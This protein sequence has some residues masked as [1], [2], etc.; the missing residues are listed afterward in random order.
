MSS[1][2]KPRIGGISQQREQY[3]TIGGGARRPPEHQDIQTSE[4][5]NVQAPEPLNI[6][7]SERL[8][9]QTS[10]RSNAQTP[11]RLRQTVY[12]EDEVDRWIRHRIA[13]TREEISDVINEAVRKMM[14]A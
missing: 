12:L 4:R 6:E 9:T 10:K 11:K 2:K 3:G 14:R 8:S 1:E 7:A 5:S 13:D